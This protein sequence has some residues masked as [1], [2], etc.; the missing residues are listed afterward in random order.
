MQPF[1]QTNTKQRNQAHLIF[2]SYGD[3]TCARLSKASKH[4]AIALSQPLFFIHP[5]LEKTMKKLILI[6]ALIC[7]FFIQA[8]TFEIGAIVSGSNYLGDLTNNAVLFDIGA[9]RP[10]VGA[11]A[12]LNTGDFFSTRAAVNYIQIFGDD[13]RSIDVARRSRNLNFRNNI[14]E[15]SIVQE[16]NIFGFNPA[17]GRAF[18]PYVYAGVAYYTHNPTTEYNGRR[19]DLQPLGTEG[20]GIEGFEDH[21]ALNGIAIP[22]GA[23]LK[24]GVSDNFTIAVEFSPRKTNTDYLDDVSTTYID[25]NLLLEQNGQAAADLNYRGYEFYG[26]TPGELDIPNAPRGNPN[27]NDW[28]YTTSITASWRFGAGSR[29]GRRGAI[30]CPTF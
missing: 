15:A 2:G 3:F 12:R 9:T 22:F 18:S 29:G 26:V 28:Y 19:V 30:G 1:K 8:Q 24:Y 23:G 10:S 20:Q 27:R 14:V 5:I 6:I 21:Y 4:S 16:I 17:A 13:A 25:Y 11:F 7:P